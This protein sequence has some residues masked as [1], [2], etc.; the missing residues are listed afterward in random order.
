MQG[1][2]LLDGH[3]IAALSQATLRREF[4]IVQQD[5]FVLAATVADNIDIGRGL[6]RPA[7]EAAARA[8]GLHPHVERLPAGYDTV[9]DEKGQSLSAGQRQLLSL[10]RALAGEPRV[11]VL[12]EATANVDSATEAGVQRA[13]LALRGRVTLVV[14]AHRLSTITQAD[15]ILV[16]HQ[17]EILQQGSHRGLLAQD[18]LYKHLY[19]LQITRIEEDPVAG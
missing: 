9:L 4:A 12:D 15:R 19:E 1:Q 10:A 11:L 5:S 7:I 6:G 18:G 14:I 8:A 17:G 2:I 16:M 3:D 13:L